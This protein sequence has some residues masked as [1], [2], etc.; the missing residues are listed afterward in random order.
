GW[1]AIR[2]GEDVLIAAPTGSGKT[3]AAFL[4]CVDQ[5]LR[6]AVEGKLTDETSVLYVS[7]LK[8]LGNAVQIDLLKLLA[9]VYQL[10]RAH[11]LAPQKSRVQV[12]SGDTRPSERAGMVKRPPHI[13][14]TTPESLY[15]Y[16][17][18]RQSR[19][20]LR[21]V[22]TVIV[23]EI[24]ALARDKRGSHF[25]LSM[26]RLKALASGS[27]QLI[28]LSAT[29][30]PLEEIAAFLTG[31]ADDGSL[32]PCTPVSVGH[33]R[34]WEISI[35]TPDQELSAVATHEMWGQIYDRLEALSH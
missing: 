26:E 27:P 25:T 18:A 2:R 35:E 28:G 34:P 10:G 6:A 22:K 31:R 14:I 16:L 19:E 24:H 29:Q 23:D 30:K 1:P 11:G 9:E 5:L 7:P 15:L 8:A 32:R 33:M 20:K 4:A 17:T 21:Q 12:R 3:L 13:L